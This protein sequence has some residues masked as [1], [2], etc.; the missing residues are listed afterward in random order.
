MPKRIIDGEAMWSSDKLARCPLFARRVYPWLI[1][2]ADAAG[3][4]ELTNLRVI[5]GKV[6]AIRE[7]LTV[8]DLGKIFEEYQRHGLLF[9]WYVGQKTYAHWVGSDRPGR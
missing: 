6:A 7:D 2:L 9:V 5:W 3:C 4:F 1:S 8:D